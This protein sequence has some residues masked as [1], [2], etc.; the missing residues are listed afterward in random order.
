MRVVQLDAGEPRMLAA[1]RRL[2][3]DGGERARQLAHVQLGAGTVRK[4][5]IGQQYAE[6]RVR[7]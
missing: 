2:R 1:R 6:W 7:R 5:A 3:E 4:D